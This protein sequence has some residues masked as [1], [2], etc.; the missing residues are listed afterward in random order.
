MFYKNT[1]PL[2]ILCAV[3]TASA[4]RRDGALERSRGENLWG[5]A[6][7]PRC[8]TQG[9]FC[10]SGATEFLWQAWVTGRKRAASPVSFELQLEADVQGSLSP[11]HSVF[12][13]S[14]EGCMASA[15]RQSASSSKD[16]PQARGCVHGKPQVMLLCFRREA[17]FP[18]NAPDH[19]R[20]ATALG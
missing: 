1:V 7:G 2:F 4:W 9:A 16:T 8:W 14:T 19:R 12:Q 18:S 17:V 11:S 6:S 5:L 20:L 3:A 10:Q 13:A 15:Q